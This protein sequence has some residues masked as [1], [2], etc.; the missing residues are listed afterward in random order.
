[1]RRNGHSLPPFARGGDLV[2]E[3][4]PA[5]ETFS[6]QE[7]VDMLIGAKKKSKSAAEVKAKIQWL[8]KNAGKMPE[9]LH[10]AIPENIAEI[11]AN[12]EFQALFDEA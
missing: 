12:S 7:V 6:E 2:A 4:E 1:M 11:V 9:K 5:L 3:E 10:K 8:I